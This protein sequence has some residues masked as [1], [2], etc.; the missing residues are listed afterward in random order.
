MTT[1]IW[2]ICKRDSKIVKAH[3]HCPEYH[4][5]K[6]SK[7]PSCS[8]CQHTEA[9]NLGILELLETHRLKFP[10]NCAK[11]CLFKTI[12]GYCSLEL[13]SLEGH[14]DDECEYGIKRQAELQPMTAD[15]PT[16]DTEGMG[17][18]KTGAG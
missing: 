1:N 17:D 5:S 13:V 2:F 3:C 11:P 15:S 16:K 8:T 9:T 14:T 7:N 6:D 10:S 4:P 12:T 18:L